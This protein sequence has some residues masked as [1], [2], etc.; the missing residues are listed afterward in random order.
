MKATLAL[1]LPGTVGVFTP[2]LPRRPALKGS[3][4]HRCAVPTA[5]A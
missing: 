3:Q 1:T 5:L 2:V 4:G